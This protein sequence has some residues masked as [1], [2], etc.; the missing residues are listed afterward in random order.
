MGRN[1]NNHGNSCTTT[2]FKDNSQKRKQSV[3]NMNKNANR[4]I[5]K[6]FETSI[7]SIILLISGI[8][9]VMLAAIPAIA[10]HYTVGTFESDFTT[11]K[12]TFSI[13][14]TVYGRGNA[15][16]YDY[17]L[18]L[19]IKDPDGT[20]VYHSDEA[21]YEITGS[22]E[23][24]HSAKTG[25]WIIQLGIYKC[26]SWH[27]S[28][29]SDRMAY[30][31]VTDTN[32]TLTVNVTGE[33]SVEIDPD[34]PGYHYGEV[35]T[36][37]AIPESCYNFSHWSGDISGSENP[38]QIIMTEDKAVTAHFVQN[39][40]TLTVKVVGNGSVEKDPDLLIYPCGTIVNL[41][42]IPDKG[43]IFSH[44]DGDFECDHAVYCDCNPLRVNM[45]RNRTI[46]AFFTTE[47]NY[48]RLRVSIEGNGSVAIDPEKE[49]YEE[50]E[51][52]N[53]TANAEPGWS[54]V[55]WKGDLNSDNSSENITMDSDKSIVAHFEQNLYTLTINIDGCGS[56]E[57][58]PIQE[59]YL[60]G[61]LVNLTALPDLDNNFDHW[62]GDLT[63]TNV[64]EQ[65]N[66]T[67]DKNITAHFVASQ[68]G[69][70]GGDPP[71]GNGGTTTTG[72][73]SGP[74][75]PEPPVAVADGPYSGNEKEYIKFNGSKSSD[76]DGHIVSYD[77]D[78]GDG[79][80]GN[81]M[82]VSHSYPFAGEY[83]VIL[84]VTDDD[85]LTSSN[86]TVVTIIEV[87][88]LPSDPVI[89]GPTVGIVG[90]IYRFSFVSEDDDY[91]IK[92]I[93]D[94]GDLFTTESEST[95]PGHVFKASH[96][97]LK[98]G[99]YTI[100]VTAD[101]GK[102]NSTTEL[103]IEINEPETQNIPE[104]NNFILIILALLAL[105]FLL[106]FLILAKKSKKD[107]EEQS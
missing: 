59:G 15:Y 43:F 71:S 84:T 68:S 62:S 47:I 60:H 28:T 26:C 7:I 74:K 55:N 83:K 32:F 51:L 89:T 41:T 37:T 101:D 49:L 54:F 36:L 99:S 63:G 95:I 39:Q 58:D 34:K 106:L 13:G 24:N 12:T 8:S 56:V 80:S 19:R 45:V 103:Q 33:G 6:K 81:G 85:G 48:Y 11:E 21:Q 61:T 86:N 29:D 77:W 44:W 16:G 3:R 67:E 69:G 66:M 65:I 73:G 23:L 52:V 1:V 92:Y 76:S 100:K 2:P 18:K 97:W 40:Y 94:W 46:T 17:K 27:W 104:E 91:R 107:D 9:V 35:V 72:S 5:I 64:T 53:L 14:E 31:T 105:M 70:G 50:G 96:Q 75:D 30:F 98:P 88:N 25:L 42:A 20:I 79:Q 57:I 78:F 90:E 22:F 93:I 4:K 102:D 10:C 82:I 38:A 87:N